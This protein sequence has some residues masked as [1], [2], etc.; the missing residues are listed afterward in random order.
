MSQVL[1]VELLH[2]M[3]QNVCGHPGYRSAAA[4]SGVDP[5]DLYQE[6]ALAMVRAAKTYNPTKGEIEGTCYSSAHRAV[7]DYLRRAGAPPLGTS[8]SRDLLG[9]RSV[10]YPSEDTVGHEHEADT[11]QLREFI[12]RQLHTDIEP[13][14]IEALTC[15]SAS[16]RLQEILGD[17]SGPYIDFLAGNISQSEAAFVLQLP[18]STFY[19]RLHK[20]LATIRAE[21]AP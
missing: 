13:E 18:A 11:K 10:T 14:I 3:V 4:I 9:L 6:A 2:I 8:R 21:Q 16:N 20:A 19:W 17:G 5:Q 1:T 12:S 15:E 7:A